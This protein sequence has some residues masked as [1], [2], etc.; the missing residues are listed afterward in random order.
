MVRFYKFLKEIYIVI[1]DQ[2]PYNENDEPAFA[3]SEDRTELWPSLLEKAY[4][5]LYG[6]YFNIVAGKCH[7]VFA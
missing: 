4:A 7:R 1:D 6:G 5:K 3:R 2:L